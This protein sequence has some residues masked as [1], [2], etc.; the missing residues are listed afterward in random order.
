MVSVYLC[1]SVSVFMG[2]STLVCV[3]ETSVTHKGYIY[4][5]QL[6]SCY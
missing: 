5:V 1:V 2:N 6:Y 3:S 4:L